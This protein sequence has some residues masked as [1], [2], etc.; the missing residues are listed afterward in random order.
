MTTP[1]NA[2][3]FLLICGKL[4]VNFENASLSLFI[5]LFLLSF[6]VSSFLFF[7][8]FFSFLFFY[9]FSF[10]FYSLLFF[11]LFFFFSFSFFLFSFSFFSFFLFS[12]LKLQTTKRTGWVNNHVKLPESIS[13]HMY[14]MAILSFLI[15]DGKVDKTRAMKVRKKCNAKDN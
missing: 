7:S 14:R 13:D 4:K 8:L 15:D 11:F 10:L 9:S 3:D 1:S 6:F 12:Y 5:S 2:L